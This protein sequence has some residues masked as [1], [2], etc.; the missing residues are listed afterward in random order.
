MGKR[1]PDDQ[2]IKFDPMALG[3]SAVDLAPPEP[4]ALPV[5]SPSPEINPSV[6]QIQEAGDTGVDAVPAAMPVQGMPMGAGTMMGSETLTKTSSERYRP[7]DDKAAKAAV[8]AEIERA[9]AT[10]NLEAQA[11]DAAAKEHQLKAAEYQKAMDDEAV[12]QQERADALAAK[13]A[14]VDRQVQEYQGIKIDPNRIWHNAS[15]G[16]KIQAGVAMLLGIVG[17]AMAGGENQA[18]TAIDKAINMDIDAQK[19]NM[20]KAGKNVDVAR[21]MYADM[22]QKFGDDRI[23]REAM[24]EM[25]FNKIASDAQAR[26]DSAQS[27]I[28]KARAEQIIAAA[29]SKAADAQLA[30]NKVVV[31]TQ[32]KTAP[33]VRG[34][35]KPGDRVLNEKENEPLVNRGLVIKQLTKLDGMIEKLDEKAMGPFDAWW[36]TQK[37]AWGGK[38]DPEVVKAAQLGNLAAK[39]YLFNVSGMGVTDKELERTIRDALPTLSMDRDVARARIQGMAEDQLDQWNEY[40]KGAIRNQPLD[41]RDMVAADV[42]SWRPILPWQAEAKRRTDKKK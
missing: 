29:Q 6:D 16:D 28:I 9:R 23:A 40:A 14:E 32:K 17:Q 25:A 42:M 19:A 37:T 22:R 18:M 3:N 36:N 30:R 26:A 12:K 2:L 10:A 41:R 15:T 5:P 35:S 39:A 11:A 20:D 33:M 31:E 7:E 34:V 24:R 27:P 21:T 38:V 4:V 1:I 8:D 13:Q